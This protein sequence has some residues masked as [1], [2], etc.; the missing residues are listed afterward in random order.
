MY[1]IVEGW[2]EKSTVIFRSEPLHSLVD[3]LERVEALSNIEDVHFVHVRRM[4]IRT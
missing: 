2:N 4:A 1:W 3:M